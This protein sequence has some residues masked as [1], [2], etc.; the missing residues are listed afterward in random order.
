ME[1]RVL[2]ENN[3]LMVFDETDRKVLD[4]PFNPFTQLSWSSEQEALDWYSAI[5]SAYSKPLPQPEESLDS[6]TQQTPT[7]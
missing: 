3:S 4:Q 6:Q 1:L 5:N 2:F 7:E